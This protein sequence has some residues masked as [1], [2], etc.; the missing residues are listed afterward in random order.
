MVKR[1]G[2][3]M[4]IVVSVTVL[5]LTGC[6]D[7]PPSGVLG[8]TGAQ[9][10]PLPGNAPPFREQED[11][12]V[13]QARQF[14]II[15]RLAI[16]YTFTLRL[17]SSE[18]E[19]IQKKHLAECAKLGCT[20]L[21]THLDRSIEGRIGARSTVRISP[22][23]YT[24]FATTITAAPAELVSHSESTEDKTVA[25]LDIEKRLE[26]KLALRD[27]LSAMLKDPGAKSP[28]DLAAIEKELA[29]VQGDIEA[30]IAQR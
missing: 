28:A 26:V 15:K 14:A 25:M 9:Y 2:C 7:T 18:V 23:S 1:V 20:V 8:Y 16:S 13:A 22:E 30:T 3:L 29:Q 5:A 21:N 6:S 4:L 24:S 27:R 17:P 11:G 10:S 19:A 12:T